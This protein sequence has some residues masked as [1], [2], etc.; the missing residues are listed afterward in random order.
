M[1]ALNKHESCEHGDPFVPHG[2]RKVFRFRE[3]QL[4][5]LQQVRRHKSKKD[6]RGDVVRSIGAG[7]LASTAVILM[8][9]EDKKISHSFPI[10]RG[11]QAFED[12]ARAAAGWL[13]NG[14]DPP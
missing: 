14:G 13:E 12:M 2:R 1:R 10:P 8:F 3:S 11:R 6:D 9:W 5:D 4:C 7:A